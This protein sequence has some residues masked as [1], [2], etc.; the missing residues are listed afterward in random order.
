[1]AQ[2]ASEIGFR[3]QG[4]VNKQTNYIGIGTE[5]VGPTKIADLIKLRTDGYEVELLEENAFL[6]M[7][8]DS[9][10]I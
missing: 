5:N 4:N 6:E 8:L 10:L 3:V 1:M 2:Y 9:G 7:V